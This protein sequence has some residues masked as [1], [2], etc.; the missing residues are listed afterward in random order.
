LGTKAPK[1]LEK[2]KSSQRGRS[3]K[4][5]C[6]LRFV[7]NFG[8]LDD[9]RSPR[10]RYNTIYSNITMAS[11]DKSCSRPLGNYLFTPILSGEEEEKSEHPQ[12]SWVVDSSFTESDSDCFT[13]TE[14]ANSLCSLYQYAPSPTPTKQQHQ[15]QQHRTELGSF[16]QENV[17]LYEQCQELEKIVESLRVERH[18]SA[19]KAAASVGSLQNTVR[20]LQEENHGLQ[21]RRKDLENKVLE[22]RTD[23]KKRSYNAVAC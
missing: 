21:T 11:D 5:D 18:S 9:L 8:K 3:S 1:Q 14:S 10:D 6:W 16:Q 19:M 13:R 4:R 23:Y 2:K 17:E 7:H 20:A 22:M 15:Q 12:T